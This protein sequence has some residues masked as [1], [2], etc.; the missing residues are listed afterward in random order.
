M[1]EVIIN[2]T[3]V[4][5]AKDTSISLV[6]E[7]PFMSI[8]GIPTPYSFSWT[9]P[10]TPKNLSLFGRS[11]RVAS[12]HVPVELPARILFDGI[13]LIR[14]YVTLKPISSTG[15]EV[16]LDSGALLKE[17]SKW[18]YEQ[19]LGRI[20]FG[21]ATLTPITGGRPNQSLWDTMAPFGAYK[22]YWNDR[23]AE[24]HPNLVAAP[25]SIK[26]VDLIV[27]GRESVE[28]SSINRRSMRI[29]NF[30]SRTGYGTSQHDYA[31]IIPAVRL[32][33]ILRSINP[34]I[35]EAFDKDAQLSSLMLVNS[36]HPAY[37]IKDNAPVW[38]LDSDTS[39][40]YLDVSDLMPKVNSGDF[41]CECLKVACSS[42]YVIGG[43]PVVTSRSDVL[44]SSNTI[45]WTDKIGKNL[46]L[47]FAPAEDYFLEYSD[48]SE[49]EAVPA[50][51][52]VE[53]VASIN[54]MILYGELD[55]SV[56]SNNIGTFKIKD[57]GQV[58]DRY[59]NT[60]LSNDLFLHFDYKMLNDM[61]DL[62]VDRDESTDGV[63]VTIQASPVSMAVATDILLD[64][65]MI[66]SFGGPNSL[67]SHLYI[68][69]VD[70][71]GTTR[72]DTLRFGIYHGMRNLD[73]SYPYISPDNGSTADSTTSQKMSLLLGR[74]SG[75]LEKRH[76]HFKTWNEK[77]R[78]ILHGE[79]CIN[80]IDLH[81]LDL[82]CKVHVSGRDFLI[83]NINVTI[84][85]NAIEPAEIELIE[86]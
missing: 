44:L 83:R 84:R 21:Y 61:V 68:P 3:R 62:S 73:Y 54:T 79:I 63:V 80:A 71:P 8:D 34:A 46:T 59:V 18:L 57:S 69:Q 31:K 5:L 72:P 56:K 70:A 35:G 81:E 39:E 77:L 40:V 24:K 66:P 65:D 48:L 2:N 26:G 47:D 16:N 82:R 30:S 27:T 7:N 58:F 36:W 78:R 11:D 51:R 33:Y 41:V 38:T 74:K 53:T 19:D 29:N 22:K 67:H 23:A 52:P 9:L 32:A 37:Q 20:S 1:L 76:K 17:T 85:N 42:L 4:D 10:P 15:I 60:Q 43:T 49:P 14:G 45:D 13:E 55:C 12:L 28:T 86:V 6:I 25:L 64:K 50:E 75:L